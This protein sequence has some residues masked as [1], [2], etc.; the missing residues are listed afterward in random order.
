MIELPEWLYSS[1]QGRE[2][3]NRA[4]CTPGYEKGHLMRLAGIASFRALQAL[5]P[6]MRSLAV[7][8]GPGNNGGDGFVVAG[9]AATHAWKVH[10]FVFGAPKT[11]DAKSAY[12]YALSS[13]AS[14]EP[15]QLDR[16]SAVD[17]V[18]DAILGSGLNRPVEGQILDGIR[19]INASGRPVLCLDVPSGLNSDSGE[20]DKG[21]VGATATLSF[22]SLKPGI[23]M[24]NGPDRCGH[25][26]FDS[27][28]VPEAIYSGIQPAANRISAS[29]VAVMLKHLP[30]RDHKGHAGHLLVV[31]GTLGMGG[32]VCLAGEAALRAG[33]G[34]VSIATRLEHAAYL[35]VGCPELMVSGINSGPDLSDL[36]QRATAIVV[37]PGLG[38]G[39]WGR[40][41][42][43]RVL[44]AEMP[45][46]IDADGLNLLSEQPILAPNWILTPHPG[47][48]GRLLGSSAR[49]V[50]RDRLGAARSIQKRYGG[51]CVLKGAGTVIA[52]SDGGL[53][54]CN[55]GNPGMASAGMGDL[56]A[57]IIGSLLAQGLDSGE[58]AKCGT[59]LHSAAGDSAAIDGERGMIARD[60]FPHLRRLVENPVAFNE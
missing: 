54:I 48:A 17:V 26:L 28:G 57:G 36:L 55:R 15:F 10:L 6:E 3:D 27:L 42:L 49:E 23:V 53:S 25:V 43:S 1:E 20:V 31:G 51:I 4:A 40:E 41:L 44:D 13:G 8:C 12:R 45:L 14:E 34:L 9:L 30:R 22:I 19:G 59:W 52:T 24:G 5:W 37:G 38:V 60:L 16:L 58:A 18:V 35:N 47:E 11:D 39:S 21:A 50:Q 2:L 32:A 7:C 33:A 56:L 46:V 29:R